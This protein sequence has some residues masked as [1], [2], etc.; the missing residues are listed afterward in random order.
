MLEP[1]ALKDGVI[2]AWTLVGGEVIHSAVRVIKFNVTYRAF[3]VRKDEPLGEPHRVE[4]GNITPNLDTRT[5]PQCETA[6]TSDRVRTDNDSNGVNGNLPEHLQCLVDTTDVQRDKVKE[7]LT[8][9]ADVFSKSEFDLGCTQLLPHSVETDGKGPVK[10]HLLRHPVAYL[11]KVDEHMENVLENGI[12][13]V[14]P[15][16]GRQRVGV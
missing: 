15:M 16:P 9:N 5:R 7:F 11:P 3:Q 14:R 12:I 2:A 13:R 1:A 8:K 4:D 6:V 10:Q